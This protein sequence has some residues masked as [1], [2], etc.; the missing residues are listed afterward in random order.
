M[1]S[2]V[3]ATRDPYEVLG[4]P[5]DAD[6]DALKSAYRQKALQYHPD[7]NPGDASAEERFK[8]VSEA[9]AILRDPE[10]RARYDRYGAQRP[11]DYRHDTTNVDWRDVFRDADI[12]IDFG[13]SGG[14]PQTGNA[15]FDALFGM[16]AGMLRGAGMVAG[17]TYDVRLG[18]SLGELHA[19]AI[20]VVSVPGPCVCPTC[21]GSGRS[22]PG[23]SSGR[24]PGPFEASAPAANSNVCPDCGG[25]GVKRGGA[26]LKVKVPAG[27]GVGS[28]LR[29]AGAGGPGNPPGDVMVQVGWLPPTGA[30]A[31]G[32]DVIGHLVLTPIEGKRG[33]V[34]TFDGVRVTVPADS[35]AGAQIVVPGKGL[36]GAGGVR[37][38][39]RLTLE[40][41]W[42]EGAGRAVG[43]WLR[44]LGIGGEAR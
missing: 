17:Q 25:R 26:R 23:A 19:G 34:T 41:S 6:A 33:T 35:Q 37:G 20:S 15:V 11:A 32:N 18:L 27:T 5:R 44:K 38:D 4:V 22:Q 2:V 43:R 30:T 40:L 39:L 12:N 28:K 10:A 36:P 42:V 7:R 16:M 8:E 24:S 9:Y 29:L 21:K 3:T 1:L 31:R 13:Q 14:I